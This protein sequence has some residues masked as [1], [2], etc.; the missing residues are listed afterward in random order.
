MNYSGTDELIALEEGAPNYNSFL[1]KMF[2]SIFKDNG[3]STDN[4]LLDFG[5]GIGTLSSIFKSKY[6]YRVACLEVDPNQQK[7]LEEKGFEVV[8][9]SLAAKERYL[10]IY[11][12]NVLEHIGDDR[13]VI[14]EIG[15]KILISG[16]ILIIY[17]PALSWLYSPLDKK[18]GHY[19]R[20]TKRQLETLVK[21]EG[22]LVLRSEYVDF[23]GVFGWLIQKVIT[24]VTK[25]VTPNGALISIYDSLVFPFSRLIDR[26]T[27]GRLI[28]KNVL[29]VATKQ[30]D[31][32]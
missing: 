18:L 10:G 3:V 31:V 8:D 11:L 7:V 32:R 30:E 1:V 28:G 13:G 9:V 24:L 4:T 15:E 27:L 23:L 16:G 12:S 26:I 21:N 6:G 2:H 22:F 29:V 14:A 25:R 20:Y 5:A 17:V 19:R